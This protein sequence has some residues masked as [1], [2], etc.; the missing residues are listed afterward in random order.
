MAFISMFMAP[1]PNGNRDAYVDHASKAAEIFKD[2]GALE[3]VETWGVDV[4][5]GEVTSMPMAVKLGEGETVVI[6]WI[7]WPSKEVADAA[8]AAG[9]ACVQT[10]G[11]FGF[12]EDFDIERKFR[13]ARLYQ[14]APIS[15][16]LILSYVAEHVLG[17]PRSY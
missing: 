17:M 14:V 13:E 6:G 10:H 4:P 5:D 12:A 15:T 16:N 11:G 2:L 3:V 1:V 8:W 9:E 7:R